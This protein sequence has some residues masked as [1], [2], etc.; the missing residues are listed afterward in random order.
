MELKGIIEAEIIFVD[1]RGFTSW[2]E[3]VDVFPFLDEFSSKFYSIL[4]S[5]FF[6]CNIKTLGDGAMIIKELEINNKKHEKFL[7]DL[8]KATLKR[9]DNTQKDFKKLC[10]DLSIRYGSNI[11]LV[12][13]WGVTKGHIKKLEGDYIGAEINKSARLCGIARDPS[14][15]VI[16]KNDFSIIPTLPKSL[17]FQFFEQSRKLNGMASEIDVWVSKDIANQFLTREQIRLTPEVHVAGICI[18]NSNGNIQVL[19][20]KRS[21][22]RKLFPNLFEGCGGQL[23]GNETFITGVKRHYKLEL[24]IVVDVIEHIHRF[25][26]INQS[27]EPIIPGVKFL[28]IYKEGE[29]N[30]ENHTEIRWVA[31]EELNS[32][33]EEHF[34]PGLKKDFLDFIDLYAEQH[35][36]K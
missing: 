35:I 28:C 36:E 29:P 7:Q 2:A 27:N 14:D 11:P 32:M 20:A 23:A 30:S 3:N 22:N 5:V 21:E 33:P 9:I 18:K 12:L 17:D 16:D 26:Y 10:E 1:V 25:Y 13:G 4:N 24:N 31:K 15:I 19:I 8:I 34:I 6:D